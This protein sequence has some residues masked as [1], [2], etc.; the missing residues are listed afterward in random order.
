MKS[1]QTPLRRELLVG[2]GLL[3]VT[4]VLVAGVGVY[5][6][7]PRL[8]NPRDAALYLLVLVV[9]DLAVLFFFG[10]SILRRVL[11]NPMERL[12]ADTRRI[13]GGAYRHRARIPETEELASLAR[14]VNAMADR[15][16][17]EQEALSQNVRSL[18]RT[19][20]ELV[21]ARDEVVRA[22]RLASAGSL[23]AGIAHEVG[24]PL[25][26]ILGYV[27]VARHRA[28]EAGR[29][30]ELLAGIREEAERIDRIVR[31]LLDY[32]RPRQRDRGPGAPLEVIRR[33]VELLRDQG[34]LQ[35]IEVK[36]EGE[37][38]IPRVTLHPHRLEHVLVN[39][40][41]NAADALEER[42]DPRRITVRLEV[43]PGGAARLPIRRKGDPE[44]VDYAHRRRL[45]PETSGGAGSYDPLWTASEVVVL[46]V[47]DNGPGIPE[48][49]LER[50][51]DPFFTTK[52]P[53]QGTG[54][55]LAVSARLV[56]GM[57]G[58]IDVESSPERGAHFR[59]R[60][61][62][63]EDGEGGG[64]EGATL[65][66]AGERAAGPGHGRG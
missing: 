44:G 9:A 65:G 58:R 6:A 13:A 29:D 30:V 7:A 35:G 1:S 2:F 41:L 18:E 12:V 56:E 21:R 39:L 61:P 36:V 43:E 34:R 31:G 3:F 4:A 63:A 15:L 62:V 42:P 40:L 50:I 23:A 11:L 14:S 64:E 27:D 8:G 54:L 46:S 20:R 25:G 17:E 45:A 24:N 28:E 22:A 37:G 52:E 53:G 57:G 5:L 19:N 48:A 47:E 32:A 33:V 59:I 49:L 51:F 16:I 38:E 66:T 55:G 60:L 10:R 26:A